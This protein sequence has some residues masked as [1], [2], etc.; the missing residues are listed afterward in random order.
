MLDQSQ[1]VGIL[2]V[3]HGTRSELGT[4]QYLALAASLARAVAPL[5]VEPAFLELKQ[6]EIDTAVGKL[7]ARGA[8]RLVTMP[9]LLFAAGHVKRDIPE[10]VRTALDR[11]GKAHIENIQA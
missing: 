3:G 11:R 8:T 9:L 5:A 10:Q 2:L 7:V 6:P 4:R 1:N